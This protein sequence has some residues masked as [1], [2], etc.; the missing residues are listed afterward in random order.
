[1]GSRPSVSRISR[2]YFEDP[3]RFA[4]LLAAMAFAVDLIAHGRRVNIGPGRKP[5][6][7]GITRNRT[8]RSRQNY[9]KMFL[10]G[11]EAG[12]GRA[13]DAASRRSLI[14]DLRL[15][16]GDVFGAADHQRRSLMDR[17]GF[18]IE[19]ATRPSAGRAAGVF[20]DE[21]QRCALV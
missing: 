13:A 10:A 5:R 14:V 6:E 12:R 1:M 18:N 3:N 19:D 17:A 21:G 20:D 11:M 8:R 9:C 15:V 4:A 2:A 16:A 7:A